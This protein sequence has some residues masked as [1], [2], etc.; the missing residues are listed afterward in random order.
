MTHSTLAHRRQLS[1]L[2][3]ICL[4]ALVLPLSFTGGAIATPA[5]GR[6]LGGSPAALTWITNA[7]MLSFGS[8]L[9][10]AGAL[11]DEYGRRRVFILGMTLFIAVS[12][13]LSLAPTV[14]WLDG[15]RA[16]QGIAAAASLSS[17]SAAL[18]QEFDGHARTRAFS[19]LA[20]SFGV[21]LSFGPL[22]AGVLIEVF[23]WRAIFAATAAIGAVALVFAAPRMRET[24][25]PDATGVDWPGTV[26]FT[27]VLVLFTFGVIQGPALGWTSSE[28]VALLAISALLLLAFVVVE[29]RVARPMLDLGL[30]RYPR[31]LGVQMLPIGTCYCYIVLVV[32]LP[33]RFIGLEG[34]SELNAGL[35]MLAL[36]TPLLVVP[37]FVA[38][39]TRRIPA[40]VLCGTGFLIAAAGLYWLSRVDVGTS[41]LAVVMPML[42]IGAGAGMPWGLMD[43]LAIGVVPGDRAGMA[44][45][46][47]NTT[48]VAGEGIALAVAVAILAAAAQGS[49]HA[50]LENVGG[51]EAARVAQA[52]Q[53]VAASDLP[54]A[55]AMLPELN[56]HLV[57][58]SY[59]SAFQ[60]LLHVLI[61]ITVLSALASFV[62]LGRGTPATH[63]AA[64]GLGATVPEDVSCQMSAD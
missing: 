37:L 54:N 33:L 17:G 43:G 1:V 5:I 27:G 34:M 12:L 28:V 22:L 8:L 11:A 52:A 64:G 51:V 58:A 19:L 25:D 13:G 63:A 61:A 45:G 62:F 32:L 24:R 46:I 39:L 20:T 9:M 47:F 30:L 14:G 15:L 60:C 38:T 18:A 7:F 55:T 44:A 40:G 41:G 23:G 6:D 42:L 53:R 16:I 48:R 2:V 4:A 59:A 31:F 10:A 29:V 49:L 56:R 57:I 26:L 50:A 21:G 36:S 35:L 3:S